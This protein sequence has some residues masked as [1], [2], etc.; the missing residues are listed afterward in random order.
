MRLKNLLT[1]SIAAAMMTV[2]SVG[3]GSSSESGYDSP[4]EAIEGFWEDFLDGDTEGVMNAA[5]PEEFWDSLVKE[6]G[7]NK[8]KLFYNLFENDIDDEKEEFDE[9]KIE[10]KE[11]ASDDEY[12][13]F[14]RC[15]HEAGVKENAEDIYEVRTNNYG[16][17]CFYYQIDGDWYYAPVDL[18]EYAASFLL[19]ED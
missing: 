6:S 3:C 7:L 12:R 10:S 5:A 13:N 16:T 8:E 9:I 2:S 15:M 4:E 19:T 18:F 14:N 17:L 11:E 1:L